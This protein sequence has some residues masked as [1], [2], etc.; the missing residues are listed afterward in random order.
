MFGVTVILVSEVSVQGHGWLDR[1]FVIL[2]SPDRRTAKT[3]KFIRRWLA[4][5]SCRRRR[6]LCHSEE[7]RSC[8]TTKNLSQY[9]QQ[10]DEIL[11]SP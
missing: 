10:N 11:R 7:S 5:I 4:G 9:R 3:T 6:V 1:L 8:G 2:R